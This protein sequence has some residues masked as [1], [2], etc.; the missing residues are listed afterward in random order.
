MKT[1]CHLTWTC[2]IW[3]TIPWSAW[4]MVAPNIVQDD[5]TT[6][7]QGLYMLQNEQQE[8][9][10]TMDA[11]CHNNTRNKGDTLCMLCPKAAKRQDMNF[12]DYCRCVQTLNKDQC[13]IVM[14]NRAWCK[15]YIN[16]VRHGENQEGYRIL[17]TGPR[18]TGKSH[19]VISYKETS[20]T[21]PNA[22]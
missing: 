20:T 7:V 4:E 8:K 13:N 10:D 22:Q 9:E 12:Q 17:L 6:N 16:T 14:Y 5:R 3:K 2:K 19:V 18:G 15:S 11:V 1:V 21:F